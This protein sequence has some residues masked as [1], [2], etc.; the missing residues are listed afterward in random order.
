MQVDLLDDISKALLFLVAEKGCSRRALALSL[1]TPLSWAVE[2]VVK[3]LLE[4]GGDIESKDD[5][6]QTP[7]LWAARNARLAVVK[8]LPQ[9]GADLESKDGEHCQI[10]TAIVGLMISKRA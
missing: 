7:L 2:N 6:N 8:L 4:N 5:A 9:K 10:Y 3:L 1:R